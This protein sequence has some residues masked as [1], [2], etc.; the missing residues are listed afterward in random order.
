[1]WFYLQSESSVFSELLT[2]AQ[3]SSLI[4]ITFEDT[5]NCRCIETLKSIEMWSKVNIL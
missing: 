3:F 5:I 1:M 2:F 4:N